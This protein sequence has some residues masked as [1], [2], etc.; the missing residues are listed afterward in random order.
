MNSGEQYELVCEFVVLGK[1]ASRGSKRPVRNKHTG[2]ICLIDGKNSYKY[3]D[4][5][6]KAATAAMQGRPP[7]DG[8]VKLEWVAM[9][10]RPKS[11][12]SSKGLKPS[13]PRHYLQ[14]PDCS[15]IVRGVEDSLTGIVYLDDKQIVGYGPAIHK[16][17]TEDEPC[18]KV[19]V[20]LL[21]SMSDTPKT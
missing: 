10:Q 14:T 21:R 4:S 20:W 9:F 17:W 12:Y 3:M 19:A 1:A 13:A 11:H 7:V 8:P 6:R 18:T 15:K 16:V 5:I 2:R